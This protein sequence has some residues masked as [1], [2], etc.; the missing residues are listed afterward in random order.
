MFLLIH[1]SHFSRTDN[2]IWYSKPH[3]LKQDIAQSFQGLVQW[4]DLSPN[5]T[6]FY[7]VKHFSSSLYYFIHTKDQSTSL[8]FLQKFFIYKHRKEKQ[9]KVQNL[10]TTID[11]KMFHTIQFPPPPSPVFPPLTNLA[12]RWATSVSTEISDLIFINMDLGGP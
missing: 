11:K 5:L 9:S 12:W 10:T 2:Y 8:L 1:F 4:R 6:T 7:F 3:K